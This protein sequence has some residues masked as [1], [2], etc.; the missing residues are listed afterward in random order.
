MIY[1]HTY[2][3][4]NEKGFTLLLALL[5]TSIAL[6]IGVSILNITLKEFILANITRDSE[7][8]FYAADTGIECAL[9][10][11]EPEQNVFVDGG[12]VICLGE[13]TV[14]PTPGTDST[15]TFERTWGSP[16]RC[17]VVTVEKLDCQERDATLPSGLICTT[18]ESRGYN[19]SCDDINTDVRTVERGLR[20]LY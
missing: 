18:I 12:N 19:R 20:A 14:V 4:N 7:I 11:D 3:N 17:A 16:Q 10:W 5:I 13:T 9:F 1:A 2:K 6:A 15:N 8:A